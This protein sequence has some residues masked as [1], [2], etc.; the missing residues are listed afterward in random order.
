VNPN[1]VVLD[2]INDEFLKDEDQLLDPPKVN[3]EAP[4]RILESMEM[5]DD[6]MT[7]SEGDLVDEGEEFLNKGQDN[8]VQTSDQLNKFQGRN[9]VPS[10]MEKEKGY[11]GGTYI[12]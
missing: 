7:F 8:V 1:V 11:K 6:A 12:P 3:N 4:T 2:E 5:D 10:Q 9:H